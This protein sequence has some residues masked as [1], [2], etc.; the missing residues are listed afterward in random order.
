[1]KDVFTK[2]NFTRDNT[3]KR[4]FDAKRLDLID[5]GLEG[6]EAKVA[7]S[8]KVLQ[9]EGE[10]TEFEKDFNADPTPFFKKYGLAECLK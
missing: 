8:R 1:L 7:G 2:A 3:G 10:P 9:W 5:G 6:F 4:E